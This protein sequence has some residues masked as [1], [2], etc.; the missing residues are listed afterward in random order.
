[1]V[2]GIRYTVCIVLDIGYDIWCHLC[3]VLNIGDIVCMACGFYYLVHYL[4]HKDPANCKPYGFWNPLC[5][6]H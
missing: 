5:L 6:G 2:Y 4:K 1:M 3:K